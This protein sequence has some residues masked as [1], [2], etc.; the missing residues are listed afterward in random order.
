MQMRRVHKSI[1]YIICRV[2]YRLG[3]TGIPV[4][5]TNNNGA[6]GSSTVHLAYNLVRGGIYNCVVAVGF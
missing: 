1:V 6:T 5:N 2:S 3:M 4:Y